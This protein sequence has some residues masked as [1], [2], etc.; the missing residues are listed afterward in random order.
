[1]DI[2]SESEIL[3]KEFK[4]FLNIYTI[5]IN[6]IIIDGLDMHIDILKCIMTVN[7]L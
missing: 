1:M 7:S 3:I 6:N 2:A 4:T 5:L